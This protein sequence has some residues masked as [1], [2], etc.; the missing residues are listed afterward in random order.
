VGVLQSEDHH[1]P[2]SV[3]AQCWESRSDNVITKKIERVAAGWPADVEM[4]SVRNILM[5]DVQSAMVLDSTST[6]HAILNPLSKPLSNL[7]II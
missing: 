6:E 1:G 7:Y 5:S 4:M 3:H 2:L